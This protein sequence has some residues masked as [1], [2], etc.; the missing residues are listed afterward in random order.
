VWPMLAGDPLFEVVRRNDKDRFIACLFAPVEKQGALF[1]LLAFNAEIERIRST[2]SEPQ[3]GEIRLQWWHDSISG[4]YRNEPQDHPIAAAL[5]KTIADAALPQQPLHNLIDAHQFDLYADRMPGLSDVEGYF[6]DTSAA[7][8][9]LSCLILSQDEAF[10]AATCAGYSGVAYGLTRVLAAAPLHRN[11]FPKGL[12][13]DDLVAHAEKRAAEAEQAYKQ[14]PQSLQPAF[15]AAR[16]APLYL[17]YARK[18]LNSV[19]ASGFIVPQWHR[20]WTL[21]RL[22]KS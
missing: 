6:G 5:A 2:V 4:I 8:I 20:Q 13:V 15:L 16:L 14:V 1:S 10:Q 22:S 21:W 18:A 12:T 11:M 7:L 17:R 3:I 19:E 9:Q